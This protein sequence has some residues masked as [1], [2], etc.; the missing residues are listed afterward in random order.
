M[1]EIAILAAISIS[2]S[3]AQ[4]FLIPKPKQEKIDRGKQDDLRFT[5]VEEGAFIPRVYGRGPVRLAGNL[6]WGTETRERVTTTPGSSGG[7]KG[8][9]ATPP[10]STF[11]YDKSFAALV[12]EGPIRAFVKIKEGDRDIFNQV[13]TDQSAYYEAE[14][15]G[16]TLAGGAVIVTDNTLLSRRKVTL[17]PGASVQF[18]GVRSNV[19][20]LNECGIYYQADEAIPVQVRINGTTD[21]TPTL[22]DTNNALGAVDVAVTLAISS[23]NTIKIT[24]NHA[25]ASLHIDR[26]F[27]FPFF[28]E[29]PDPFDPRPITGIVR[30]FDPY[31][32]DLN[33][34]TSFYNRPLRVGP[35]NQGTGTVVA[36]G[37]AGI[38]VYLGT[39]DQPVSPTIVA[40][41][42]ANRTPAHRGLATVVFDTYQLKTGQLENLTF[43]VEP[44]LDD[45]ADILAAE[46]KLR[47]ATDAMIDFEAVRGTIVEGLYIDRL[48]S[49]TETLKALEFF[50]GFDIVPLDGKIK[51]VL[52]GGA[53]LRTIPFNELLAHEEGTERPAG[54]KIAH[55]EASDLPNGV[56]IAYVDPNAVQKD[57][58]TGSQFIPLGF[59]PAIETES[60][61]LPFVVSN[62]DD[63]IAAGKRFLF[64][65]QLEKDSLE[66]SLDPKHS[67]LNPTDVV[68]LELPQ[69]TIDVRIVNMQTALPGISRCKALPEKAGIYN[70]T[71][72]GQLGTG[73]ET[74]VVASPPNS[75]LYIAD[76]PPLID[77]DRNRLIW[78]AAICPRGRGEFQGGF[79]YEETVED[80]GE[81]DRRLSFPHAATI[82]VLVNSLPAVTDPDVVDNT[83]SIVIDLYFDEDLF[84]SRPL[85]DVQANEVNMIA[86]GSGDTAEVVK[87]ANATYS[88]GTFPFVRRVTLTTLIRAHR[89]T[90][91]GATNTAHAAGTAAVFYS[92]AV[93][94]HEDKFD[95]LGITRKFKAVSVGQALVDAPVTNFANNGYSIAP[96]APFNLRGVRD[97]SDDWHFAVES[98]AE[99]GEL[100]T[101][102]FRIRRPSDN[103]I[104]RDLPTATGMVQ[105][106]IFPDSFGNIGIAKNDLSLDSPTQGELMGARSAQDFTE[107]G[108]FVEFTIPALDS[109]ALGSV[110]ASFVSEDATTAWNSNNPES[111]YHVLLFN[112]NLGEW[113]IFFY[114]IGGQSAGELILDSVN[115]GVGPMRIRLAFVGTELRVY[116][117]WTNSGSQPLGISREVPQDHFP[118]KLAMYLISRVGA[119]TEVASVQDIVIGGL[120][121][122]G[123]IYSIAQ[124]EHDNA[125]AGLLS[126]DVECW[127]NGRVAGI[128]IR[129]VFT[130]GAGSGLNILTEAG[131]DL[132]TEAGTNLLTD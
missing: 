76:L 18:N 116:K 47:G 29:P 84:E 33:D 46:F 40:E 104:M 113:G 42:G 88:A 82:G 37:Q 49:L 114:D 25:T 91:R 32:V 124:Q 107:A 120:A 17:P 59:G 16:N 125:G 64:G 30:E 36:G 129:K 56:Y 115:I 54:L 67:D 86:I 48:A 8:R 96:P 61:N 71:G 10:T 55:V 110:S 1:A 38:E 63:I 72:I 130:A 123:T 127:Q 7:K 4:S 102:T 79:V 19:A 85:A 9:G 60:I 11:S 74:G 97:D 105:A 70:Q 77:A 93:Q 34:P 20:T 52:R 95:L 50:Y 81:F 45:L 106:A 121:D 66:F 118:L 98:N 41:E 92:D 21:H 103:A 75:F 73:S 65:R 44:L 99:A 89:S 26:I 35:N 23:T 112:K 12:C 100:P 126:V 111:V 5:I 68:T 131:T 80:S 14:K 6:I 22:P 58:H 3:V 24:N 43:Y 78:Y 31:P 27:V 28:I 122:P 94:S 119:G 62:P 13:T 83:N 90:R 51:A 69:K 132:L 15:S 117:N 57:F 39:T 53:S 108:A 128:P 109:A 2:L 87:F 101:F